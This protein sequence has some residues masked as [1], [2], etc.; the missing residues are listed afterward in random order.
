M[1]YFNNIIKLDCYKIL[2]NVNCKLLKNKKILILGANGFLASIIQSTL[3]TSNKIN[4]SNCKIISVSQ[5]EPYGILKELISFSR[6]IKF[7]KKDLSQTKNLKFLDKLKFDFIFHCATYGQPS[8]WMQ[9]GIKTI[10]L[11]TGTL[12][13]LLDKATKDKSKI[14]FFSSVDVYGELKNK[15]QP[16]DEYFQPEFKN[17]NRIPYKFSKL[18]GEE[19]C[20]L[21][22]KEYKTK[23]YIIRAAHTYG[24]GQ[25]LNDKRAI[26]DFL[27]GAIFKKKIKLRDQ[28]KSIK[29]WGYVSDVVTMFFNIMLNGKSLTYNTVGNDYQSIKKVAKTISKSLP[30]VK[31]E[32]P[33]KDIINFKFGKDPKYQIFK[34]KNYNREFKKYPQVAIQEGI[35][36]LVDWNL[37]TLGK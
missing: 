13:Y 27:R 36:R 7:I 2:K 5:R 28:G 3:I 20:N 32:I 14:M 19:L 30:N 31:L 25:G 26:C 16:V 29:T 33:K 24:P 6:E 21:Y 34:A 22:K 23:V 37:I 15:K 35:Q 8:K 1:K 18:V 9:Q 12:K 10:S 11:N 17:M 4:N